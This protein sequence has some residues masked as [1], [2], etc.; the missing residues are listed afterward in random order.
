MFG[1]IH[2]TCLS[3]RSIATKTWGDGL[4]KPRSTFSSWTMWFSRW[5]LVKPT[6][7][8]EPLTSKTRAS[9]ILT[10]WLAPRPKPYDFGHSN[11]VDMGHDSLNFQ[12][13]FLLCHPAFMGVAA[14]NCPLG[15]ST[16]KGVRKSKIPWLGLDQRCKTIGPVQKMFQWYNNWFIVENDRPLGGPMGPTLTQS[17]LRQASSKLCVLSETLRGWWAQSKEEQRTLRSLWM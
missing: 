11:M 10:Q 15:T 9:A 5:T 14:Q 7:P 2:Q 8:W 17:H 6:G 16:N 4:W 3:A 1:H 12:V 13:G